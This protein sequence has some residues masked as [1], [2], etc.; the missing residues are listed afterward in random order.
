MQLKDTSET[1]AE[2]MADPEYVAGYLQAVLEEGDAE[3]FLI[4]LRNIARS[5]SDGMK[6]LTKPDNLEFKTVQTM[7][8]TLGLRLS[9]IRD[10]STAT[11]AA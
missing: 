2:D 3:T 6:A 1:F 11:L 10:D 5:D 7:L 9:V 8:R 4:A